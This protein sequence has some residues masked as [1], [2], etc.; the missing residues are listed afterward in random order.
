MIKYENNKS[1]SVYDLDFKAIGKIVLK[2]TE[3]WNIPHLHFMIN[4]SKVDGIFEAICL[5]LMFF[6]SGEDIKTSITNLI[7]N[8]L[9]YFD[10]N[11]N[12]ASDL[13]KLIDCVDTNAMDN[14][15]KEYRKIDYELAKFGKD[16]NNTLEK[17]IISEVEQK[18]KN[19]FNDFL[20]EYA[21]IL[22]KLH[23]ATITPKY[24]IDEIDLKEVR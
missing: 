11:I 8:I 3:Y 24:K 20:K 17:Q 18:Y 15:W 10:N 1:L 21:D 6:N 4:Q 5:E 12:C 9:E 19:S 16:I 23:N 7:T 2:N 22:N 14:Y 13:D